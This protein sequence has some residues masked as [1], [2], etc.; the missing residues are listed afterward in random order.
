MEDN[1]SINER[2]KQKL[3]EYKK[4][5]IDGFHFKPINPEYKDSS[6]YNKGYEEGEIKRKKQC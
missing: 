6:E 4:G 5:F 1:T 3:D 2:Y